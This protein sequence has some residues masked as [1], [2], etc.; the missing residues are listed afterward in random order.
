M[1]ECICL[2]VDGLTTCPCWTF[3]LTATLNRLSHIK[4]TDGW[5]DLMPQQQIVQKKDVS[6]ANNEQIKSFV[7]TLLTRIKQKKNHNHSFH[8]VKVKSAY[9]QQTAM[10]SSC[11]G[12]LPDGPAPSPARSQIPAPVSQLTQRARGR[13]ASGLPAGLHVRS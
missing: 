3:P 7:I 1:N 4:Q 2:C 6:I 13:L 5:I 11:E 9:D 8:Y 10:C 12:L